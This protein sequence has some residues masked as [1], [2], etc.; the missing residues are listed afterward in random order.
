MVSIVFV[1]HK[2]ITVCTLYRTGRR[3][4]LEKTIAGTELCIIYLGPHELTHQLPAWGPQLSAGEWPGYVEAH[5]VQPVT[6]IKTTVTEI[7]QN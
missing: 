5:E 7:S 2:P 4:F 6:S 3:Y 1:L